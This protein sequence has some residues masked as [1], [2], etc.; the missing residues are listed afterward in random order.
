[1]SLDWRQ[2]VFAWL[3]R[4]TVIRVTLGGGLTLI[5]MG[6][7]LVGAFE[8]LELRTY[9]LRYDL[10]PARP[11]QTNLLLVR[12][13]EESEAR[14]NM[15]ATD[16]SRALYA[17][18]VRNLAEA[19]AAMI[20]FD[21]MFSR[22]RDPGG[23]A[24][25]AKAIAEASNVVLARY[26]GEKEHMTPL[27]IFRQG[28]MSEAL[29]NVVLDSDGILRSVPLLGFDYSGDA[30]EPEPILAMSLEVARLSL[31]PTGGQELD[32]ANSADLGVGSL[33]IP[34]PD[35]HMRIN[36]YGPPGSFPR[37]SFWRAVTGDL[38]PDEVQG[39][40]VLI[41]A[42]APSQHDSYQTPY[43]EKLVIA[44]TGQTERMR[45][46]RMDGFEIHANAIQTILDR[47]FVRRSNDQWGLVPAL[48]IGL[49]VL[50]TLLLIQSRSSSVLI[51]IFRFGLLVG[52]GAVAYALF[53]RSRYWLDIVP[54][55]SLIAAQYSAAVSYQRHLE[56]QKR[57][58]VQSLFG[59]YV[60]AQVVD[61]LVRNPEM[62]NPSGRKECLT[63]F[64]SDVRGFTSMAE[65]MEPQD[66]Q[67]L[68]SEYFTEMTRILFQHGGTLDKFMGDA[69]MAFF[70]NPEPQPD[71]ALRAVL[72]ALDMQEAITKLNAKW[73]ADG[74]QTIGVG[75]GINT[76]E[77]TVGN[78]GSKD[79]LDY[80][81]IGDTVNLAC[82]LEQNARAG[83]IIMTQA[84]YDEVKHVIEVEQREPIRVKGK[85]EAIPVY[86]VIR[87]LNSGVA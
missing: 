52:I 11:F 73:A 32:L 16:I 41:G 12:I 74:R 78:L 86:R 5:I 69:V 9:D 54:M 26:I 46:V 14:L 43:T 61:H 49:G 83:E 70:G 37:L 57:R 34:Y 30:A 53:W 29:I 87:W 55:Y 33:R 13:D 45:G 79:F 18:A 80:T 1:M 60:S 84:T 42:S 22:P 56:K 71:H 48:L 82:R 21:I 6:L 4:E 68:L 67:R 81:V 62:A 47:S 72:M 24:D 59:R 19:G 44:L 3:D 51:A 36:F 10:L 17:A 15:R 85:S 31:D 27:P 75:M 66:V 77:V 76:G 25:F 50:G 7:Y 2:R 63:I 65:K 20:V 23:D 8:W 28:E 64:F 58:Q 39:K 38:T 40:I 35:G